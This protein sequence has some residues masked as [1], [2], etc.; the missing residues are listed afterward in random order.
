MR[1]TSEVARQASVAECRSSA[2]ALVEQLQARHGIEELRALADADIATIRLQSRAQVEA[3][4]AETERRSTARRDALEH[5]LEEWQASV[6]REEVA[7]QE[8]VTAFEAE[9]ARFF[10]RLM[11][12][13]DPAAFATLA[14][15]IPESPAFD[16][17]SLT[18]VAPPEGDKSAGR[19]AGPAA[20]WREDE[21]ET[22][23][24]NWWLDST[25]AINK[26]SNH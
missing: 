1:A 14:S 15:Q 5:E 12:G 24:D 18:A 19:G 16:R 20:M 23:P 22:P 3:V 10:E 7:V 17:A 11:A 9:V 4:R 26:R 21:P 2:A 25:T 6:A 13:T 8:R